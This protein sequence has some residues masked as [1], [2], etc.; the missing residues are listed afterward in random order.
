MAVLTKAV[1]SL[2]GKMLYR[3]HLTSANEPTFKARKPNVAT[4]I[5]EIHHMRRKH[6]S[7]VFLPTLFLVLGNRLDGSVH[8]MSSLRSDVSPFKSDT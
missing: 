3:Y 4:T 5:D 1:R 7:S 6:R 2:V 8:S